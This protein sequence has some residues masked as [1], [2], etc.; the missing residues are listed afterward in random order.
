[1]DILY[2]LRKRLKFTGRFYAQAVIPFAETKRK[3]DAREEP[4]VPP[5]VDEETEPPFLPEWSEADEFIDVL[6]QQC[7][8]MVATALQ[9][10][11]NAWLDQFKRD[12][13]EVAAPLGNPYAQTKEERKAGRKGWFLI[14]HDF[15]RDK[16]NVSWEDSGANV[17]LV[18]EVVMARNAVQHPE[19]IVFTS[20][21]QPKN[22]FE[23]Y[24]HSFFAD[25][26]EMKL[27]EHDDGTYHDWDTPPWDLRITREKLQQAMI[28]VDKLCTFLDERT[29]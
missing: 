18:E 1:M 8:S 5:D 12:F 25:E 29:H 24:K 27:F 17:A 15:F 16:L 14:L 2:F 22:D 23:K 13:P 6:G 9:L 20:A 19:H 7:V 3:I 26:D 11:L 28:E 10:Y 4:F 21:K